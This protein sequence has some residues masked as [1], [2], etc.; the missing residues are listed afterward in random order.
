M[1]EEQ[2]IFKKSSAT[3]YIS[4]KFFEESVRE[5]VF[6][7]YSFVRV[8]DDYVDGGPAHPKKLL[9]LEKRFRKATAN[10]N[11]KTEIVD[12]DLIDTRVLKNIVYL[13]HKYDFDAVWVEDFFEAMKADIEPKPFKRLSES[14]SYVYGSAEVIGLMMS[15][16]LGIDANVPV[17][18]KQFQEY[19]RTQGKAMQWINFVRDIDE[20]E[21]L[22]RCYFPQSDLKRFG[23]KDLRY[24]TASENEDKFCRFVRYQIAR[25]RDWQDEASKGFKHIPRRQLIPLKTAVDMYDWTANEIDQDPMAVYSKKVKPSKT[26]VLAAV[27]RNFVRV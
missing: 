26:R 12:N 13:L 14:L 3:Y 24:K 8:A 5:D 19:A 17:N 16:I 10:K 25:Y 6:R 9:K 18:K 27:A 4:S 22:G 7:L 21:K 11:Y 23:L 2:E 20:D 1:K 15:K